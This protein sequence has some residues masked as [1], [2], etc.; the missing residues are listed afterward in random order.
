MTH[1]Q[2]GLS[3]SVLEELANFLSRSSGEI[4]VSATFSLSVVSMNY[5]V[6]FS[7]GIQN[8][9][10]RIS[11]QSEYGLFKEI[12]LVLFQPFPNW[13]FAEI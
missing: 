4:K 9:N 7:F 2:L 11:K 1:E 8:F 13:L 6:L 10:C 3:D 12:Q 5:D